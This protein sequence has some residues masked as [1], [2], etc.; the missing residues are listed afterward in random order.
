MTFA[1]FVVFIIISALL[2]LILRPLQ[3]W[4]EVTILGFLKKRKQQHGPIIDV[5][6]SIKNKDKNNGKIRF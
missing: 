6:D 2:F 1:E 5:T 3:K 4:L